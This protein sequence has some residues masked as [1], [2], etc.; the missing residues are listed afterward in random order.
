MPNLIKYFKR[1]TIP[2]LRNIKLLSLLSN[3]SQLVIISS[4]I[5]FQAQPLSYFKRFT[6]PLFRNI[7]LLSFLRNYCLLYTSPSPRD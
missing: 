1:F 5:P 7:K 2:L 4:G 3:R 6:I